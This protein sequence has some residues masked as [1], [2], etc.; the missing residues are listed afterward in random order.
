MGFK[1]K[2]WED[3]K[4][5]PD[6]KKLNKLVKDNLGLVDHLVRKLVFY[7]VHPTE[8]EDM[9]QAGSI[10]LLK[11]FERYNPALASFSTYAYYCVKDEVQK[12]IPMEIQ[13]KRPRAN[14]IP[15]ASLRKMEAIMAKTGEHATAE[16]MGIDQETMDTWKTF[17]YHFNS[18]D[19]FFPYT[20]YD[21]HYE[22]IHECF[23]DSSPNPEEQVIQ[24]DLV[25][26]MARMRPC[27]LKEEYQ[28]L[29]DGR[30]NDI[31]PETLRML[32]EELDA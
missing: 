11:A 25:L 17:K 16:E 21:G 31:R 2:D 28:A 20:D 7:S 4:A 19:E 32:K 22:Y 29:F 12:Y 10:G 3:W 6:Q 27:M 23:L 14:N 24:N 15:L 30:T 13:V 9:K 8:M 26:R 5:A 18:P 1:L